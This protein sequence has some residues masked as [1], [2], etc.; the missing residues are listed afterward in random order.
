MAF[1]RAT[2]PVGVVLAGAAPG[3]AVFAAGAARGNDGPVV[4][5]TRMTRVYERA[6]GARV[7][8]G[9]KG[10]SLRDGCMIAPMRALV[11]VLA[12][13]FGAAVGMFGPV[14]VAIALKLGATSYE[15]FLP[16]VLLT[17]PLFAALFAVGAR[18][19][20]TRRARADRPS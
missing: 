15:D 12:A 4:F 10:V 11:M 8:P 7:R 1:A 5:F 6:R 2:Q 20:L 16:V 18:V 14:L 9:D 19:V 17:T 3:A 13:L